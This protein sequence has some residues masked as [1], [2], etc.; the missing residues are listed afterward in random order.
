MLQ[1]E[2]MLGLRMKAEQKFTVS[3]TGYRVGWHRALQ[4]EVHVQ[5]HMFNHMSE[6]K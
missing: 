2:K 1:S 4:T 5:R 3:H 6:Y